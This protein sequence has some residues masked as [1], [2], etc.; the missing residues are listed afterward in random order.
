V[1]DDSFPAVWQAGDVELQVDYE[2]ESGS[3]NDGVSVI[4][5]VSLLAHLDADA[6]E[7]NVPGLREELVTALLRSMPKAVRKPFVP[8]PDT[9]AEIMPG[10]ERSDRNL[11][12]SVRR[13]LRHR[14]GDA[15]PADALSLDRLPDHLRPIFRVVGDDGETIAQGRDLE[16][17]R[18]QLADEVSE[19]LAGGDHALVRTGQTTWT[20]GDIPQQVATTAA[21]QL[22]TAFPALVDE[23]DSVGLHLLADATAQHESMWLGTR[24]L[25]RR[26][27]GGSARLLDRLLDNR[28]T[29]A[30]AAS[31]HRSKMAWVN[32]AADCVFSRLLDR[33]DGPVWTEADWLPSNR[34]HCIVPDPDG[35]VWIG[36]EQGMARIVLRDEE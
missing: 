7:W 17:L 33:V 28:A 21:G 27:V 24:R 20:F 35:G 31:P 22:V 23:G 12:E 30:L 29:L 9:V 3:K 14:S 11:I 18:R 2:F 13:E 34:I 15:L 6:F 5:P 16:R 8:I 25:L 4:V 19:V 10:L 1:D 32:D 36:T 26:N